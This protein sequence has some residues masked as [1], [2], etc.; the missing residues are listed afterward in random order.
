M[1]AERL[2][3]L[4]RSIRPL[5]NSGS[6]M[7]KRQSDFGNEQTRT[8]P[9]PA[10]KWASKAERPLIAIE[11]IENQLAESLRVLDGPKMLRA[12]HYLQATEW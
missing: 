10:D 5:R 2:L 3:A 7:P 9:S 11:G 4:P 6:D 8:N 12:R 1:S